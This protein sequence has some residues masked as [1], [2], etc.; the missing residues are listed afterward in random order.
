MDKKEAKKK[1][2][3]LKQNYPLKK[4]KIYNH[5]IETPDVNRLV[6]PYK[7]DLENFLKNLK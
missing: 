4:D 5:D 2:D 3:N 1:L 6:S 7:I